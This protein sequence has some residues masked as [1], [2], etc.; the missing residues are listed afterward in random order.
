VQ[1]YIR[2]L[3]ERRTAVAALVVQA[4]AEGTLLASDRTSLAEKGDHVELTNIWAKSLLSRM[5]FTKNERASRTES[6]H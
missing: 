5:N 4:T 2:K 1:Q 6:N 3:C